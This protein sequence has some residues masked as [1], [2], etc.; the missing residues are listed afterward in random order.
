MHVTACAQALPV[1]SRCM[2]RCRNG[3]MHVPY[4]LLGPRGHMCKGPFFLLTEWQHTACYADFK[5][6]SHWLQARRVS[7]RSRRGSW[8]Q[9]R[10]WCCAWY[11][12]PPKPKAVGCRR[13]ARA[14]ADGAAAGRSGGAGAAPSQRRAP[15][16]AVTA[17]GREPHGR[18]DCCALAAGGGR[19]QARAA[20]HPV[21]RACARG[22]PFVEQC[23]PSNCL[24]L[25]P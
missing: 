23:A 4:V 2:L 8:A 6:L 3:Y 5:S 9:R 14:S 12:E 7:W 13:G 24:H 22:G 10:R 1:L 21:R 18:R 17:D 15:R 20:A 16:R 25:Q 19:H 11:P